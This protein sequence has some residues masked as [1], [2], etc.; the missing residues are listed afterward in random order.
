MAERYRP[1]RIAA[2]PD[3]GRVIIEL[4]PCR[5]RET[6]FEHKNGLV[7]AAEIFAAL[8]CPE[9]AVDQ[10]ARCLVLRMTA[11]VVQPCEASVEFT[12]HRHAALGL[13]VG[14]QSR[15]RHCASCETV[16]DCFCC[17]RH[18]TIFLKVVNGMDG[19]AGAAAPC[20]NR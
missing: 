20:I 2:Q 1:P 9:A 8:E 3:V 10:T 18:A 13:C 6:A 14:C 7:A 15:K 12:V 17:C 11:H 5:D 16:Q 19:Q 4:L